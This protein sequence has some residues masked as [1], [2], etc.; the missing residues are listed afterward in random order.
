[1]ADKE[2]T[3]LKTIAENRKARHEYFILEAFEAGIE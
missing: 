1:M 3:S 2:K